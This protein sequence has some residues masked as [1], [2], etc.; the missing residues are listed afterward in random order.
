[1]VH[2]QLFL[3]DL[4]SV[5]NFHCYSLKE[6]Y[7][8]IL[9]YQIEYHPIKFQKKTPK[10]KIKYI[11]D[12]ELGVAMWYFISILQEDGKNPTFLNYTASNFHRSLHITSF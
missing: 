8:H 12:T 11:K 5:E 9:R 6:N 1:M 2:N 3:H 4:L 7:D 10:Y